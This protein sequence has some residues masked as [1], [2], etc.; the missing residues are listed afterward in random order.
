MKNMSHCFKDLEMK[1][2]EECS[3]NLPYFRRGKRSKDGRCNSQREVYLY[4]NGGD[5][6][7]IAAIIDKGT[8]YLGASTGPTHIAGA[9]QKRIVGIYPAKAT[10]STTRWGVFGNDKVKYLVPD[11]NNPKEN[12]KIHILIN[13]IKLWKGSY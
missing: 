5:L 4:A 2:R 9:L 11:E 10:Q 8:I 12:Y 3:Y 7:N 6:L 13:M 1:S